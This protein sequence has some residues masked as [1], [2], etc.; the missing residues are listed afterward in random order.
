MRRLSYSRAMHQSPWCGAR[1][2][3]GTPCQ[4]P[5]MINGRCRMN[6]GKS[7]CAPIG[8]TNARKHGRYST[9]T[10]AERR[11][12]AA[13]IRAMNRQMADAEGQE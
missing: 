13:L 3:N 11:R 2:W 5:A 6:G 4:S 8:N 7:P 1:T 10:I 12:L 9:D